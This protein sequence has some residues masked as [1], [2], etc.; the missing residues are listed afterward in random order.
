[1]DGVTRVNGVMPQRSHGG[2]MGMAAYCWSLGRHGTH[3]LP[4]GH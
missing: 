4:A 1:M 3:D 2:G